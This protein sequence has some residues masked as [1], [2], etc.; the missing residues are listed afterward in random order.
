MCRIAAS[1]TRLVMTC[2][3]R[4]GSLDNES[5]R[6]LCRIA[7]SYERG[8]KERASAGAGVSRE[9]LYSGGPRDS[10]LEVRQSF[11]S[12]PSPFLLHLHLHY[13]T[14][15]YITLHYITSSDTSAGRASRCSMR[16]G[17]GVTMCPIERTAM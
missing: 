15:H 16:Q 12:I 2:R 14:L 4:A 13:I 1:Y 6:H 11:Q 7:A 5:H 17:G 8:A 3:I 9:V 10:L